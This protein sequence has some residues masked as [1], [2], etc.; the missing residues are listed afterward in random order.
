MR[1]YRLYLDDI[2]AA[3]ESI[4][5]FVTGMNLE[6]FQSDDKTAVNCQLST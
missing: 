4:D 2:L 5:S 3:M 1:D 6:T